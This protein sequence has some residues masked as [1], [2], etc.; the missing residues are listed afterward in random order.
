MVFQHKFGRNTQLA[1]VAVA[2]ACL[3][4]ASNICRSNFQEYKTKA[5]QYVNIYP[6]EEGITSG[7]IAARDGAINEDMAIPWVND[8]WLA[9]TGLAVIHSSIL[10]V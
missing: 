10:I 5:M 3:L 8:A 2:P 6:W 7:K 4:E 1:W 9:K